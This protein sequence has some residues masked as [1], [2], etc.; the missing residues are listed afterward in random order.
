MKASWS[1]LPRSE[2]TI[3]VL[4]EVLHEMSFSSDFI[5][6]EL[7]WNDRQCVCRRRPR[8]PRRRLSN[9]MLMVVGGSWQWVVVLLLVVM[10]VVL[11]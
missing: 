4:P 8:R 11:M 7:V 1:L 10:I 3:R 9:S 5:L 6:G 2:S